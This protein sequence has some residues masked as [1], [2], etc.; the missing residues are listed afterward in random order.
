MWKPWEADD[1]DKEDDGATVQEMAERAFLED[2]ED[3]QRRIAD[4]RLWD[5]ACQGLFTRDGEYIGPRRG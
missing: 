4:A 3:R 2:Q 1:W 5:L